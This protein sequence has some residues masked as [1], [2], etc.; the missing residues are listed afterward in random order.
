MAATQTKLPKEL[1]A[2]KR[3]NWQLCVEWDDSNGLDRLPVSHSA[4]AKH[5][6]GAC[7]HLYRGK[8]LKG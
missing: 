3:S 8:R 4:N 6:V 7:A 1:K 2:I 5:C